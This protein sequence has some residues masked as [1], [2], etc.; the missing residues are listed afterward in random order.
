MQALPPDLAA[1]TEYWIAGS[2]SKS[3]YERILR[4]TAAI[5]GL[6]VRFLG[7]LP[8][9]ELDR[10]YTR[11]DVFALTSI[12]HGHSVEGFGLVYLEASAH[13]LPVVA[14]RVGG[15]AE[16]VVE[17]E[18]GFLIPPDEP[19]ALTEAFRQL[20]SDP[21]LRQ[22]LGE[23]GRTWARS[24]TWEQ[25]AAELFQAKHITSGSLASSA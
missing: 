7:N 19:A 21:A 8:D 1:R 24:T 12:D 17:G 2:T 11:A 22:R 14:H 25:A 4:E 16:A 3:R 9:D 18:T 10:V 5:P 6:T 13:G 15:V 20:L 23:A